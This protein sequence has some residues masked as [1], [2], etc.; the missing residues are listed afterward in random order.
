MNTGVQRSSATPVGASTMT[1]PAGLKSWGKEQP[2]KN[3]PLSCW[4]TASL[5]CDCSIAYPK[6]LT[7]KVRQAL[8]ILG[9]KYIDVHSPCQL[10]GVRSAQ[11]IEIARLAVQTGLVPSMRLP[12]STP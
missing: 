7:R 5:M 2:K 10:G 1:S 3:L 4:R 11:T 6:D 12:R 9:P 8:S